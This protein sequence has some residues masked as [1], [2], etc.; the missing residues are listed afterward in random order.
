MPL[1]DGSPF[2]ENK[3]KCNNKAVTT[4]ATTTKQKTNKQTKN[5]KN[6]KTTTKNNNRKV[7]YLQRYF[8]HNVLVGWDS[9]NGVL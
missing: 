2:A 6:K 1:R 7:E 5:P 9:A 3:Q 8:K 4:E